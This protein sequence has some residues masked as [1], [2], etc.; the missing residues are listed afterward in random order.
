MHKRWGLT[1]VSGA[2]GRVPSMGNVPLSA[3]FLDK[4]VKS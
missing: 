3:S 2:G 1:K 4:D